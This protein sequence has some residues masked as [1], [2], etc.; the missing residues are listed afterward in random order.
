MRCV[1][2]PASFN[3]E[4]EDAMHHQPSANTDRAIFPSISGGGAPTRWLVS[5]SSVPPRIAF[6]DLG[7]GEP[8][9]LLL[10]GWCGPR[11]VY[12]RVLPL[13]AR[14]RRVVALDFRG[15]GESE[16]AQ[17]DFG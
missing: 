3:A 13:L 7:G 8:A 17:K 5:R 10:P 11:S 4:S 6:D 12:R 1:L 2:G 9:L 15:H 14:E 16:P